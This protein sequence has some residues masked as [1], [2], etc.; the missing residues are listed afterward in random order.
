MTKE[1]GNGIIAR[2]MGAIRKG[3]SYFF[4]EHP[5]WEDG[6]GCTNHESDLHYHDDWRWIMHA[7]KRVKNECAEKD[8]AT[9]GLAK[10]LLLM[11][12]EL[13]WE[14]TVKAIKIIN[15]ESND[16]R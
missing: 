9:G 6:S 13:L 10:A 2:H 15:D 7:A 14:E 4:S 1:E 8:L 11:D 5:F 3:E 12:I 16:K